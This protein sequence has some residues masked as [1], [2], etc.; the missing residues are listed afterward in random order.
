MTT[1]NNM[2]A[3]TITAKLR[4]AVPVCFFEN[5]AEQI[6]YK[7]IDIPDTLKE[8]EITGFEFD[9][10]A[11]GKI[12]FRLYF[13]PGILPAEFPPA[14]EKMTRAERSAAKAA[15][16]ETVNTEDLAAAAGE[17]IAAV[18]G[19]AVTA[20]PADEDTAPEE[21]ATP[22]YRF[23]VTGAR[24]KELA[25]ILAALHGK[26]PQYLG[27]PSYAYKCG[28]SILDRQGTLHGEIS[29]ELLADLAA[30]DFPTEAE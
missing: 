18:T 28:P 26:K 10:P 8:L 6:R 29:P 24:R 16:P 12:S 11:D 5:E 15:Q 2:K 9:V 22:E 19:D 4:D 25:E 30:Q 14:R 3:G 21:P 13:A 1:T 20:E 7:N 17:A 23:N 27:A